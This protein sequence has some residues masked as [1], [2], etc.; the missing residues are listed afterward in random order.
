[1]LEKLGDATLRALPENQENIQQPTF[2]IHRQGFPVR[3]LIE[4]LM[5]LV[6]DSVFQLKIFFGIF[7]DKIPFG[8]GADGPSQLFL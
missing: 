1:M 3:A 7:C 8:I 4:R 5:F 2:N 6:G